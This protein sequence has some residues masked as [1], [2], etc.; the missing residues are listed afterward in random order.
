MS[1]WS[2]FKYEAGN[3]IAVLGYGLAFVALI[4]FV[5]FAW[6]FILMAVAGVFGLAV[7][8]WAVGVPF[9]VK[10]KGV[11]VGRLR[12]FTYHRLR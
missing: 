8:L 6:T 5:V 4:L 11:V 2:R 7:L 12:W 1:R 9:N 3:W 10:E